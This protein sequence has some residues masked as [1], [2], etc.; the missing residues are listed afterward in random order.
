M[1]IH[2][3]I[4]RSTFFTPSFSMSSSIKGSLYTLSTLGCPGSYSSSNH[5]RIRPSPYALIYLVIW[6]PLRLCTLLSLKTS[7]IILSG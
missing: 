7:E 5:S 1:T 3:A 4:T 2:S 6:H